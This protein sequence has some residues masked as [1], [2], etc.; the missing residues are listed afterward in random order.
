MVICLQNDKITVVIFWFVA[1][2]GKLRDIWVKL[3]YQPC[4]VVF[5]SKLMTIEQYTGA[6]WYYM[7]YVGCMPSIMQHA[8]RAL[9]ASW[10]LPST[11]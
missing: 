2:Q 8:V 1:N 5:E 3:Q 10:V 9:S 11:H 7:F 6:S 4:K